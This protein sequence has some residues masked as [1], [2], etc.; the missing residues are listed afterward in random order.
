MAGLALAGSAGAVAQPT[1]VPHAAAT[2]DDHPNQASVQRA[3]DTR[4]AD[5]DGIY[6]VVYSG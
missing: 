3:R 4:D 5:G 6:S 1:A 2:C